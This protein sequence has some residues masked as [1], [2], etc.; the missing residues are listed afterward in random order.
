MIVRTEAELNQLSA[1][2]LESVAATSL[3]WESRWID[4]QGI[5]GVS[6]GN[7]HSGHFQFKTQGYPGR[8]DNKVFTSRSEYLKHRL[9]KKL[10][11]GGDGEV[12]YDK[13]GKKDAKK[14]LIKERDSRPL[15]KRLDFAVQ[16]TAKAT[17]EEW[18]GR[19]TSKPVR[20]KIW[21]PASN[22]HNTPYKEDGIW[23][24][25]RDAKSPSNRIC[26]QNIAMNGAA[27]MAGLHVMA[28]QD[29]RVK[30]ARE[31]LGEIELPPGITLT[32]M[33]VSTVGALSVPD[34]YNGNNNVWRLGMKDGVRVASL[35]AQG[36]GFTFRLSDVLALET[37]LGNPAK[38]EIVE[39]VTSDEQP[40]TSNP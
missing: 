10:R 7:P 34:P 32:G 24:W 21:T 25:Q 38:Y 15:A 13:D 39:K 23:Q 3:S 22:K 31:L 16:I 9:S 40:V 2:Q 20:F 35:A 6:R 18:L 19:S 28:G 11:R 1:T 37:L 29:E 4:V 36:Y 17:L 12:L 30:K 27:L 8:W 26:T 33:D 14:A 5:Q